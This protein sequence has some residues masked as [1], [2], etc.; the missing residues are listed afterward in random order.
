MAEPL[1]ITE[2]WVGIGSWVPSVEPQ[3]LA[4][5]GTHLLHELGMVVHSCESSVWERKQEDWKQRF[6][7]I[8][9]QPGLYKS[10]ISFVIT[11]I[12]TVKPFAKLTLPVSSSPEFDL[13]GQTLKTVFL[14][15][16]PLP[17][18]TT[19]PGR[20]RKPGSLQIRTP[21][22]LQVCERR[23]HTYHTV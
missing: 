18:A 22:Q 5:L 9:S 14:Q 1:P 10:K 2:G 3:E 21:K 13:Q 4:H 19:P 6:K 12:S 20:L 8:L 11:P 17:S 15:T 16:R 23:P 7:V